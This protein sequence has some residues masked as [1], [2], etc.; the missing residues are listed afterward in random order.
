M[1]TVD[2]AG[3]AQ[4]LRIGRRFISPMGPS[5]PVILPRHSRSAQSRRYLESESGCLRCKRR[6]CFVCIFPAWWTR[7]LDSVSA[8][9]L[10]QIPLSLLF[11]ELSG[12]CVNTVQLMSTPQTSWSGAA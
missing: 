5:H 10:A 2:Q 3:A 1:C 6:G 12:Y 7:Y 8:V 11:L 4:L 9:R